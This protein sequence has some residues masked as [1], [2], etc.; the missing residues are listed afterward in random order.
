MIF[1]ILLTA[2]VKTRSSRRSQR[3]RRSPRYASFT[4][5][6]FVCFVT[7]VCFAPFVCF[8]TFVLPHVSP[9]DRLKVPLR[10]LRHEPRPRDNR[11][12]EC[13]LA[14]ARARALDPTNRFGDR[15]LSRRG[16][17]HQVGDDQ[18][19]TDRIVVRMPAVVIGDERQRRVTDLRLARELCL[20]EV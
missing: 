15:L 3:S 9:N 8:V 20:L 11:R 18:L 4:I 5:R 13:I 12:R 17:L 10:L 2:T 19:D 16:V 7:F 6:T 14:G 1:M